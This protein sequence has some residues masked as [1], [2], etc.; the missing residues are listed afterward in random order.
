MLASPQAALLLREEP[1][2]RDWGAEAVVGLGSG[3][4]SGVG[5]V[6]LE[7][8]VQLPRGISKTKKTRKEG[9]RRWG[10]GFGST[11][12][13]Q[14][15]TDFEADDGSNPARWVTCV[16]PAGRSS[17]SSFTPSLDHLT[18]DIFH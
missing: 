8:L 18:C 3:G 10:E 7:D 16:Q 1:V 12:R 5:G 9:G 15:T 6:E 17:V 4:G 14:P 2:P 11:S 13:T